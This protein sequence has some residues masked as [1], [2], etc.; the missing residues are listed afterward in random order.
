VAKKK[1]EEKHLNSY[2]S[3]SLQRM[4]GRGSSGCKRR[5]CDFLHDTLANDDGHQI[6]AHKS[7]LCLGCK[8]CY[9]DKTCVVQNTVGKTPF[10]LCLNCDEWIKHKRTKDKIM[11]PGWSLLN[12]NGDLRRDV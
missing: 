9:E 3:F 11:T 2:H 1:F 10:Y 7:Y 6:Q 12:Q 8:N 4:R 5:D